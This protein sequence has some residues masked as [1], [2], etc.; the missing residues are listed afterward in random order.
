MCCRALVLPVVLAFA[1]PAQ[2]ESWDQGYAVARPPAVLPERAR[3]DAVNRILSE[4]LDDLLPRLMREV[5]IDMWLV[6][7]RE[8]NEDPVYLTLV[9]EPVFAARRTTILVFH[10]RGPASGVDRLTVSR[11]GLGDFYRSSWNGGTKE[12]LRNSRAGGW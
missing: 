11:Y 9:P 10:D 6:I 8:Y 5:D 2:T 4:R 12:G 3:A 7:A 1:L